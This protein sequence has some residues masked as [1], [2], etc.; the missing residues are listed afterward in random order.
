MDTVVRQIN[1]RRQAGDTIV[2]VLIASVLV[3]AVLVSSFT[4]ANK[5]STQ[6]RAAQ[7]RGEA[8][9]VAGQAIEIIRSKPTA[10]YE[11]T[12]E[13]A[14]CD[15]IGSKINAIGPNKPIN[16]LTSDLSSDYNNACLTT[17]GG[18]RYYTSVTRKSDNITFE[19]HT[20]WDKTG[21]G[22]RQDITLSYR[23]GTVR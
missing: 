4:I 5:S 10:A 19:I 2:E 6:I 7:Q 13:V 22:E 3:G 20:R 14:Y 11:L 12:P 15:D 17:L 21:G 8:L 9:K 16:P 1:S 18:A 23:I